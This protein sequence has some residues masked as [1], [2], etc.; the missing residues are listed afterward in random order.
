MLDF[1]FKAK[2]INSFQNDQMDQNG[3]TRRPVKRFDLAARRHSCLTRHHH[4]SLT[5]WIEH[6]ALFLYGGQ[7]LTSPGVC[8][9][10]CSLDLTGR[11]LHGQ[12]VRMNSP[13]N[14]GAGFQSDVC[15][16]SVQASQG[17]NGRS[18]HSFHPGKI[19]RER[20]RATTAPSLRSSD[21]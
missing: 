5:S 21:A 10:Q 19:L 8:V 13:H 2:P 14:A 6:A 11:P 12:K 17:H 16:G 3:G 15:S 9:G 4:S 18:L 7:I 1:S 20:A